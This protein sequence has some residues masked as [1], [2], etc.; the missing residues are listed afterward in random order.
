M[1]QKTIPLILLIAA[2]LFSVMAYYSRSSPLL[3]SSNEAKEKIAKGAAVLDVRTDLEYSLGHYPDV[4]HIPVTEVASKIGNTI[5]NKEQSIVVYC[6]TGQRS[7]YAAEMLHAMGYK[8]TR[9]I[10]GPYW[11]LLR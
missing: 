4:I 6:N 3:L 2:L 11:T 10:T 1:K 8:N 5:P 7:R 9:Y